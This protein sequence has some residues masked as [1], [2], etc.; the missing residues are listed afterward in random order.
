MQ[1]PTVVALVA[2]GSI[3][4]D[5]N[6]NYILADS[7]TGQSLLEDTSVYTTT[8]IEGNFYSTGADAVNPFSSGAK[9]I[10]LGS[11]KDTYDLT[12]YSGYKNFTVDNF[13][14][15][16]DSVVLYVGSQT[17]I[18]NSS[19]TSV[20]SK[21]YDPYTGTLSISNRI[22]VL[23]G[24]GGRTDYKYIGANITVYLVY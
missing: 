4:K 24:A 21:T 22:K 11:N 15:C 2:D 7:T 14:V 1:N 12:T 16:L 13:L 17:S 10:N 20:C 5:A 8:I 3:Y 23:G 19:A 6:N 9:I 18:T